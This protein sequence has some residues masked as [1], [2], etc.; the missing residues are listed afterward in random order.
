MFGI[1]G[2]FVFT[3]AKKQRL[4]KQAQWNLAID[5]I[6]HWALIL[7]VIRNHWMNIDHQNRDIN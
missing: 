3:F 1:A 4:R 7:E 2:F 6:S 5:L